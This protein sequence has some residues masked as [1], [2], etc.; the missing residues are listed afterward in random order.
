M[1]NKINLLKE[2]EYFKN[3]FEFIKSKYKDKFIVIKNCSVLGAY[4]SYQE[5]VEQTNKTEKPGTFIV[6]KVVKSLD[7]L[8]QVF[9]LLVSYY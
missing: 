8:S 2:F 6:Q 4:S 7:D 5:A 9:N 1:A 3:N